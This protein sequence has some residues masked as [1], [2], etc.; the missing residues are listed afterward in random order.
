MKN[1]PA[2][3]L[4][5]NLNSLPV[6]GKGVV[7]ALIISLV[8]FVFSSAIINYTPVSETIVPYLAYI[9]SIISIFVGAFYVIKKL[10][11]KG[12]LNGGLT[13]VFYVLILLILGRFVIGEFPVFS[14]FLIKVFLGFVFGAVSGIIGR[15]M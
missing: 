11:F 13:G 7:V 5:P 8:V 12:W 1:I 10:S 9:T 14:S 15:N 2:A 6:I 3:D 4:K